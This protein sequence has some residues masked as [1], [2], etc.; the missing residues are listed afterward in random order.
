ML[1]RNLFSVFHIKSGSLMVLDRD[2]MKPYLPHVSEEK[3]PAC[4]LA[5][6]RH[7]GRNS[8]NRVLRHGNIDMVERNFGNILLGQA[9]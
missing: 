9:V 1:D 3:A 8:R 6:S 5:D 4:H 7:H 2:M